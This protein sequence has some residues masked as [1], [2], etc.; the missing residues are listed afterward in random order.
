MVLEAS[1]NQLKRLSYMYYMQYK[2]SPFSSWYNSGLIIISQALLKDRSDP[3]WRLYLSLC[4][5]AWLQLNLTYP[6]YAGIT[7]GFLAMA[8]RDGAVSVRAA[9]EIMTYFGQYGRHHKCEKQPISTFITGFDAAQKD[10]QNTRINT[11]AET[12]N[13]IILFKE[14]LTDD[15]VMKEDDE[16]AAGLL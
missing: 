13:D 5:R 15:D 1:I 6:I 12:F 16:T 7:Q 11:I 4:I 8:I 2:G 14:L 10:S 3:N 9:K